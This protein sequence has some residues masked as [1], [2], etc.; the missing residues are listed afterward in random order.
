MGLT[1]LGPLF[2]SLQGSE[3]TQTSPGKKDF[4]KMFLDTKDCRFGTEGKYPPIAIH[5]SCSIKPNIRIIEQ[6]GF[7]SPMFT[8]TITTE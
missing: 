7:N 2:T 6:I 4:R 3:F 5:Y 1:F 8:T